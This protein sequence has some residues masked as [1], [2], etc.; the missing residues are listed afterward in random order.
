LDDAKNVA[1]FPSMKGNE[2]IRIF[3]AVYD[4]YTNCSFNVDYDCD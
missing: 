1:S 2:A 4:N 3:S